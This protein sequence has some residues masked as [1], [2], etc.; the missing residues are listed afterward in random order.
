MLR[1]RDERVLEKLFVALR[2]QLGE[3]YEEKPLAGVAA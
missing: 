2:L 1:R 3:Q